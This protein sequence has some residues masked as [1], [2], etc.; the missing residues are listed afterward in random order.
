MSW[1]YIERPE[2]HLAKVR[3]ARLDETL[4]LLLSRP[5]E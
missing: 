3:A 5:W 1:Q 2:E 4:T